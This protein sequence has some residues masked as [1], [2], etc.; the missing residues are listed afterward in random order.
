MSQ[1]WVIALAILVAAH[2][3]GH[4]IF[5]VSTLG[6]AN[7]GGS[8]RSWFLTPVLGDVQTN[9]FGTVIWIL[10]LAGF[11]AAGIGLGAHLPWWRTMAT[12]CSVFSL[13]GVFL[14]Y[15]KGAK[16]Y[17]NAGAFDVL[18][19]AALLFFHWPPAGI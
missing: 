18:I 11:I 1:L 13:A 15:A 9:L 10:S 19:L 14:F 5:L 2:G 16:T 3:I 4:S 7:W 17:L 8:S 12:S 6:I